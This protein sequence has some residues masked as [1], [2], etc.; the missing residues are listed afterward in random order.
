[1]YRQTITGVGKTTTTVTSVRMT[2][3]RI[4]VETI[5]AIL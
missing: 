4:V 3:D 1:M 2:I 5:I